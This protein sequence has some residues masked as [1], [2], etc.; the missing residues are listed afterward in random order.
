MFDG[1]SD[2]FNNGV[3]LYLSLPN[4]GFVS[5]TGAPLANLEE[6]DREI[7]ISQANFLGLDVR[8]KVYVPADGYFARYLERLHNPG[9]SPIVVNVLVRSNLGAVNQ[10]RVL[11]SSSGDQTLSA[12]DL[13]VVTDDDLITTPNGDPTLAFVLGGSGAPR[14]LS[15]ATLA[16]LTGE[17][18]TEWQNVTVEPGETIVLM[19]FVVQQPQTAD[20]GAITAAERL[21]QLPPEAI[22]GLS[23]E[24]RDAIVNWAVPADGSSPL[25][26]IARRTGQVSG[27]TRAGDDVTPLAN[28]VVTYTNANYPFLN[29]SV[30]AVTSAT[31]GTFSFPVCSS[32]S[33]RCRAVCP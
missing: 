23:Q 17:I 19:H 20:T 13:W 6:A 28:S 2:A 5:F 30:R 25:E 11:A 32:R 16:P 26:P 27:V 24:E 14:P 12:Q 7:V 33:S 21:E 1:Q 31:N 3:V 10:S 18:R 4:D 8:R 9:T 22:A 29:A 15:A